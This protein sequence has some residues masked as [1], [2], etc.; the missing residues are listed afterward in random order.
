MKKKIAVLFIVV[1]ACFTAKSQVNPHAIGARI[2]GGAGYGIEV[3][4]QHGLGNKNRLEFDL[5]LGGNSDYFRFGF[6]G[7]YH[8]VWNISGGFNWYVGP[9]AGLSFNSGKDNDSGKGN[10]DNYFGL[11]VGGQIGIE[12]NFDFPL[13][14]SLDTRPMW[15][16]LAPTD[17][18]FGWGISFGI[19]YRF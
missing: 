16:F 19:R 2:G 8:W 17:Y 15:D 13:Q 1:S 3:S 9:G 7:M 5:G 6:S 4:Y 18:G 14:L 10:D 11:A 12:Y